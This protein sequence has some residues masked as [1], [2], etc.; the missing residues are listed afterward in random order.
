MDQLEQDLRNVLLAEP[1][2]GIDPDRIT[3]LAVRKRKMRRAGTGAGIGV[4]AVAAVAAGAITFTGSGGAAQAPPAAQPSRTQEIKKEMDRNAAHLR[5]VL[6]KM[7]PGKHFEVTYQQADVPG[8]GVVMGAQV[9]FADSPAYLQVT[10]NSPK[11]ETRT[12]AFLNGVCPGVREQVSTTGKHLR[13]EF[14]K[15]ADG[16]LLG[17]A[18]M[19]L[20]DT[21]KAEDAPVE[22]NELDYTHI[23]AGGGSVDVMNEAMPLD[24]GTLSP[25]PLT[26]EQEIALVTDPAL[27]M[28]DTGE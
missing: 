9:K 4:A 13:C 25:Y 1:P 17:F 27:V 20:T 19:G 22:L 21:G 3:D 14:T 24:D 7:L 10:I 26:E 6:G 5:Y 18:E 2:L 12:L 23:R 28:H 16:G 15:Q 8:N 11:A